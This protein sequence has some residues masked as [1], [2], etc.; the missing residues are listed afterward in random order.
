MLKQR[1]ALHTKIKKVLSFWLYIGC[2]C[3]ETTRNHKFCPFPV[4]AIWINW[5]NHPIE[6]IKASM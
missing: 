3:E 6:I 2:P 1:A 5:K 4:S